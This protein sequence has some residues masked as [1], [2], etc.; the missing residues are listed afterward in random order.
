MPKE[1]KDTKGGKSAGKKAGPKVK[2]GQKG[3][4]APPHLCPYNN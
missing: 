3:G 1:K 2:T 4:G